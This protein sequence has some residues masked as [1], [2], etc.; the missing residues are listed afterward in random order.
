[1]FYLFLLSALKRMCRNLGGFLLGWGIGDFLCVSSQ[2]F[3]SQPTK[4]L[5]GV[6]SS[7]F[8]NFFEGLLR[9][10]KVFI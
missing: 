9:L 3:I 8:S 6:N 4:T 1:M 2:P 10:E 7:K 5:A